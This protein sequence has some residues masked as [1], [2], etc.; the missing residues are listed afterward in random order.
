MAESRAWDLHFQLK[1]S[2]QE[3][4]KFNSHNRRFSKTGP[5]RTARAHFGQLTVYIQVHIHFM[6]KSLC[7]MRECKQQRRIK[8]RRVFFLYRFVRF[9]K[10]RRSDLG[11][12]TPA[13]RATPPARSAKLNVYYYCRCLPV[14]TGGIRVAIAT[15]NCNKKKQI[16]III[17][18]QIHLRTG[19]TYGNFREQR[20]RFC[21]YVCLIY[22]YLAEKLGTLPKNTSI[23]C[24]L[25][26][27]MYS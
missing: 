9:T 8:I 4:I 24:I 2:V 12:I 18:Q 21:V 25:D 15:K 16:S 19:V 11:P 23:Y 26:L 27:Y 13:I 14:S 3:N 6:L 20:G 10:R 17:I 1:I 22:D 5:L 7:A